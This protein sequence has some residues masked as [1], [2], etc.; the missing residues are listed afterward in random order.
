MRRVFVGLAG[1]LLVSSQAYAQSTGK[2]GSPL[3]GDGPDAVAGLNAAAVVIIPIILLILA[4]LLQPWEWFKRQKPR[5]PSPPVTQ[6][7]PAPRE[8]RPYFP[9]TKRPDDASES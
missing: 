5:R 2:A 8:R 1:S 3:S 9:Q 7:D 4:A 6:Q